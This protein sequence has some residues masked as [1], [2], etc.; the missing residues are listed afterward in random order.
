[1]PSRFEQTREW[2]LMKSRLEKGF[3]P[4]QALEVLL[5]K[6][7]QKKYGIHRTRAVVNFLKK[8]LQEHALPY[9]VRHFER[10]AGFYFLIVNDDRKERTKRAATA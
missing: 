10:E 9:R 8:Y 7:D 1:M 5:T 6:E 3:A 4:G 2:Q